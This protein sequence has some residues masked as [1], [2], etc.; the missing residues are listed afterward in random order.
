MLLKRRQLLVW[1]ICY[2]YGI[3]RL[4]GLRIFLR[5]QLYATCLL[6]KIFSY[7]AYCDLGLGRLQLVAY[8]YLTDLAEIS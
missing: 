5:F 4:I 2:L 7:V 6:L 8:C 3:L 1:H